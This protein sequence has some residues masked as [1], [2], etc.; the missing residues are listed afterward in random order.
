[1]EP[2][3]DLWLLYTTGTSNSGTTCCCPKTTQPMSQCS[4]PTRS[5]PML[6]TQMQIM[7]FS[8]PHAI[9]LPDGEYAILSASYS[10]NQ[11]CSTLGPAGN[12]TGTSIGRPRDRPHIVAIIFTYPNAFAHF[13]IRIPPLYN[14][15][16]PP[17]CY[18]LSALTSHA[19][20]LPILTAWL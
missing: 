15:I 19:T 14:S 1:V 11:D 10:S 2:F 3:L 16:I 12:M 20:R 8:P 7:L 17:A 13:S 4:Q 9:L 6:L 5:S 18:S